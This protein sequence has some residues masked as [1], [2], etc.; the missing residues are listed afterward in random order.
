M[1]KNQQ[2]DSSKRPLLAPTVKVGRK[3]KSIE[4]RAEIKK[5]C[6]ERRT[7]SRINIGSTIARWRKL[8]RNLGLKTDADMAD[9]LLSR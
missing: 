7:Q 2:T 8:Q 4:E 3:R 9:F 1:E 5:K 6:E